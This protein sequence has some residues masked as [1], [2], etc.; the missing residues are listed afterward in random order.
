MNAA[1]KILVAG[2]LAAIAAL[3]VWAVRTVPEP[4]PLV[5]KDDSPRVM[6]Y[7]NNVISEEKNGVKIWDLTSESSSVDIDTQNAEM[8]KIVGHYY[9]KDGQTL[10]IKAAE[11]KYLHESRTVQLVGDVEATTADGIKLTAKK[12]TW[13]GREEV[14]TAEEDAVVTKDDMKLTAD[15]IE[16]LDGFSRIKASGHARLTKG[17]QN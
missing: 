17:E 6:S 5:A 7:A 2:G 15:K 4:P 1:G 12:L 13:A 10:T 11:G 3:T 9:G 16:S 14:L 8:K